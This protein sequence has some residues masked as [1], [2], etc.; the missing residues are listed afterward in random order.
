MGAEVVG[1]AEVEVVERVREDSSHLGVMA[2]VRLT[3]VCC[4]HS[5]CASL[6]GKKLNESYP[7]SGE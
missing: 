7:L 3:E 2:G 4:R 6:I 5:L 1:A